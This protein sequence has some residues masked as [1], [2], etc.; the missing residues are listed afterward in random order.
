MKSLKKVLEI[1]KKVSRDFHKLLQAPK[2]FD[3]GFTKLPEN[4]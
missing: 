2:D 1:K 4:F 3:K